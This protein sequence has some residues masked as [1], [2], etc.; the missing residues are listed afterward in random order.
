MK[1]YTKVVI[2]IETLEVE[3]TEGFEY[4]GEIALCGGSSSKVSYRQSPEQRK[5]GESVYPLIQQMYGRAGRGEG[6]WDVPDM[7]SAMEN[8]PSMQGALSGVPMYSIPQAQQPTQD[9]WNN[10]SGDVKQ[11]LWAPYKEAGAQLSEMMGG[12]GQWGSMRGGPSGAAGAAMG[13]IASEG[14]RQV[15]LQAWQMGQE[16][17]MSEWN[18]Q[19]G[20]EQQDYG[21]RLR[22]A[23]ADFGRYGMDYQNKL[24]QW[25]KEQEAIEF[26]YRQAG[27]YMQN[28]QS[29]PVVSP[30]S[31]DQTGAVIG[32]IMQAVMMAAMSASDIRLK[33]NIKPIGT[34]KGFDVIE[35]E[36]LWG[37]EKNT[38][39]IAQQVQKVKPE[40]VGKLPN[41]Y[42]YINYAL[43]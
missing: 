3:E 34:Y 40:A 41:G 4:E 6:A 7:P 12:Q 38:G 9:W 22:E 32:A 17:R 8:M 36:Y 35:F 19:L 2:N 37:N 43:V 28:T 31:P 15:P 30:G 18:A 24:T 23:T 11:G 29:Q 33:K 5:V 14:A 20:R 42:L 25:G 10:V 39:L 26:P 21:N 16:G 27:G 13:K 1:I